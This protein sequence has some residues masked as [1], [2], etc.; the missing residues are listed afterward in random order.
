MYNQYSHDTDPAE[1][2]SDYGQRNFELT[3]KY[4]DIG[5]YDAEGKPLRKRSLKPRRLTRKKQRL[6]QEI[7]KLK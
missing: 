4:L 3:A 6:K 7:R 1:V 5:L 2:L